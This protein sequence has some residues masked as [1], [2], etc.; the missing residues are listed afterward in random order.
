MTNFQTI[1]NLQ[2]SEET[3]NRVEADRHYLYLDSALTKEESQQIET[4]LENAI[5]RNRKE[6]VKFYKELKNK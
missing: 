6:Q 5:E 2:E 1:R 3:L 4:I